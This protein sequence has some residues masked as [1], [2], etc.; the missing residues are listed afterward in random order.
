VGFGTFPTAR[1]S[2]LHDLVNPKWNFR[3]IDACESDRF[4][5]CVL[6][7]RQYQL[8]F[9][10]SGPSVPGVLLE[11][12]RSR[13]RKKNDRRQISNDPL[14]PPDKPSPANQC[15]ALRGRKQV[16]PLCHRDYLPFLAWSGELDLS[17]LA[18]PRPVDNSIWRREMCIF[19]KPRR[20]RRHCSEGL[21]TKI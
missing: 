12:E 3:C 16:D 5:L 18:Q 15:L 19:V 4:L 21:R 7:F 14:A 10:A 20:G 9:S 2:K 6:N 1:C 17:S 11:R 8:G 13:R